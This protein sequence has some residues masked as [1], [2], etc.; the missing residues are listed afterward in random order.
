[1]PKKL[2]VNGV[3]IK[4]TTL[5]KYLSRINPAAGKTV[6]YYVPGVESEVRPDA[7]ID[8]SFNFKPDQPIVMPFLSADRAKAVCEKYLD[9]LDVLEISQLVLRQG[10][11][12]KLTPKDQRR[13]EKNSVA[14]SFI[15]FYFDLYLSLLKLPHPR[16]PQE[17]AHK[18]AA[19][20]R[21][22]QQKL[23]GAHVAYSDAEL[24][25]AATLYLEAAA[26]GTMTGS[27]DIEAGY[28]IHLF[29]SAA[30][31]WIIKA[32]RSGQSEIANPK[33]EIPNDLPFGAAQSW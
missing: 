21:D 20:Y 14:Q 8:G 31:G 9:D 3:I 18:R 26:A 2:E 6:V 16:P 4:R 27:R 12:L 33:S 32:R 29:L 7:M 13:A 30:P 19:F 25:A 17:P 15:T 28:T 10:E 5:A 23:R 11:I 24:R 1:M 22:L